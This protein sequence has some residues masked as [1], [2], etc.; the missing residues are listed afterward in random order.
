MIR[1]HKLLPFGDPFEDV[2]MGVVALLLVLL[3][4]G[5]AIGFAAI[6]YGDDVAKPSWNERTAPLP[7]HYW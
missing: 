3:L 2:G 4:L 6:Y 1:A 5:S 7:R